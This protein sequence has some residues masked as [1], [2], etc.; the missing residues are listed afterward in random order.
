MQF[1]NPLGQV[2]MPFTI[3]IMV[4]GRYIVARLMYLLLRITKDYQELSRVRKFC[5]SVSRHWLMLF[6]GGFFYLVI[7][8]RL[9]LLMAIIN[10][11][12]SLLIEFSRSCIKRDFMKLFKFK[13]R[14]KAYHTGYGDT[15]PET[16]DLIFNNLLVITSWVWMSRWLGVGLFLT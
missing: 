4:I 8:P 11:F 9:A 7:K 14:F 15:L 13:T 12:W 16:M 6:P 3:D 10:F 5:Y 1:H 2:I